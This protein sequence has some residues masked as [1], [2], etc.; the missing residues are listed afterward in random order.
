MT[1]AV[2]KIDFCGAPA[3][4]VIFRGEEVQMYFA[5]RREATQMLWMLENPIKANA[6]TAMNNRR[7]DARFVN[8]FHRLKYEAKIREAAE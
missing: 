7:S 5:T 2:T 1:S 6:M 4:K 3:W 8:R